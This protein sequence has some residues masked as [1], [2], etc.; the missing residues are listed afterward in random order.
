MHLHLETQEAIAP[1]YKVHSASLREFRTSRNA[2]QIIDWGQFVTFYCII[3]IWLL[4]NNHS[5]FESRSAIYPGVGCG[6]FASSQS[7]W[8][9]QRTATSGS[10]Y[11]HKPIYMLSHVRCL[12]SIKSSYLSEQ[13]I[14]IVVVLAPYGCHV[15]GMK[16]YR[17]SRSSVSFTAYFISTCSAKDGYFIGRQNRS[18][19]QRRYIWRV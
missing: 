9:V 16:P 12:N 11:L 19:Y 1:V 4:A 7:L 14:L 6:A 18:V 5:S 13:I 3:S 17:Q 2:Y 15:V 8:T 10:T